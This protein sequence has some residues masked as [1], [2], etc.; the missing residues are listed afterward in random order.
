MFFIHI[1][2]DI[3]VFLKEEGRIRVLSALCGAHICGVLVDWVPLVGWANPRAN[4]LMVLQ[5]FF[6][7]VLCILLSQTNFI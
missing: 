6:C 1:I 4:H 5:I 2:F 3:I 7:F